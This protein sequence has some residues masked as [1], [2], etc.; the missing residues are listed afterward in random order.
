[1][2]GICIYVKY[3][4]TNTKRG[5]MPP[6]RCD[7]QNKTM[8]VQQH[9][10]NTTKSEKKGRE[11]RSSTN[12][13]SRQPLW[14]KQHRIVRFYL[15]SR[16]GTLLPCLPSPSCFRQPSFPYDRCPP[17]SPFPWMPPITNL[18]R[19]LL[20]F[21]SWWSSLKQYTH[22]HVL[23]EGFCLCA[24]ILLILGFFS[25]CGFWLFFLHI[26]VIYSGGSFFF[27]RWST[28]F[29]FFFRI[30][31]CG[32]WFFALGVVADMCWLVSIRGCWLFFLLVIYWGVLCFSL[33]YPRPPT[34]THPPTLQGFYADAHRFTPKCCWVVSGVGWMTLSE[35]PPTKTVTSFWWPR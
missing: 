29:C 12:A 1:M 30:S 21:T 9:K 32:W 16:S 22:E 27:T 19:S 20:I 33:G 35:I 11:N 6:R 24:E 2:P 13:P 18:R 34:Y 15:R 23:D 3:Y 4:K 17:S 31:W 14:Y 7:R 26:L 10:Y 8:R 25:C 28:K 5:V